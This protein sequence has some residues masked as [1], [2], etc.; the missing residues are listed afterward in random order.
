MSESEMTLR[1]RL[2][3]AT[4]ET[5]YDASDIN[6]KYSDVARQCYCMADAM[7]AE[8]DKIQPPEDPEAEHPPEERPRFVLKHDSDSFDIRDSLGDYGCQLI[9]TFWHHRKGYEKHA[10]DF[11][12][13]LNR[14]AVLEAKEVKP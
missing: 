7:L 1:D 9:A 13:K 14:E 4:M 6:S 3:I 2:A 8:R 10:R 5:T 12:D 11:C